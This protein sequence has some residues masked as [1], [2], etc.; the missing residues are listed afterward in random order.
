MIAGELALQRLLQHLDQLGLH[1]LEVPAVDQVQGRLLLHHLLLQLAQSL[2]DG[3]VRDRLA[4]HRAHRVPHGH[5]LELVPQRGDGALSL[6]ADHPEDRGLL[7]H[8][9]VEEGAGGDPGTLGD[10]LRR[11]GR[12]PVLDHQLEGGAVHRHAGLALL[13]LP[14]AELLRARG[15]MVIGR[16]RGSHAPILGPTHHKI[17]T[18]C[19]SAVNATVL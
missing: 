15:V 3:D 16:L 5:H 10:H 9:V 2:I 19:N 17:C 11:H 8:P 6:V 1:G 12:E 13:L 14:Q 18:R 4:H 7:G